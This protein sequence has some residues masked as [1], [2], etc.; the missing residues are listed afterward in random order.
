MSSQLDTFE[1][2]EAARSAVRSALDQGSQALL[3]L[4]PM[5]EAEAD[6]MGEPLSHALHHLVIARQALKRSADACA[7]F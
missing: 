3:N 7:P 6:A 2:I 4:L 1:Y 5:P